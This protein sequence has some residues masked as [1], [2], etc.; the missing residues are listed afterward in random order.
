MDR[1]PTQF[2]EL[3]QQNNFI[4]RCTKIF[5]AIFYHINEKYHTFNS[6]PP[7]YVAEQRK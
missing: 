7:R 3:E 2:S 6:L 4:N 5:L 1:D